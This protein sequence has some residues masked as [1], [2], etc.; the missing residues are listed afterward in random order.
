MITDEDDDD[1]DDDGDEGVALLLL[2]AGLPLHSQTVLLGDCVFLPSNI[3][4][5]L[6]EC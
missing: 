2:V 6:L 5:F 4:R 1:D 3:H